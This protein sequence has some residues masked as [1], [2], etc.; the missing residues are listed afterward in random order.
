MIRLDFDYAGPMQFVEFEAQVW[1][2]GMALPGSRT[3]REVIRGPR[4]TLTLEIG[5]AHPQANFPYHLKSELRNEGTTT[6]SM[7]PLKIPGAVSGWGATLVA[8]KTIDLPAGGS[9]PLWVFLMH[10]E[11]LELPAAASLEE[12]ASKADAALLIRGKLAN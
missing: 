1:T 5:G 11:R 12:W 6:S 8:G 10:R 2:K 4:N 9:V 7:L 3:N